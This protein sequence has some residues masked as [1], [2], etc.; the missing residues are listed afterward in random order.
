MKLRFAA[1]TLAAAVLSAP[2]GAQC[3]TAA[4]EVR[5]ACY[6]ATDFFTYLTPQFATALAGGSSTLGQ[7][8]SLGGLGRFALSLRGTGIINGVMPEIGDGGFNI[9]GQ[10][11]SYTV[12]DQIIPGAGLDAAVGL[13]KGFN[14]G[15]TRVGGIDLL[16]SA[17]YI[18][19]VDE[20]DVS[21]KAKDGNL[22]LGYGVR[23]GLLDES[24]VVPG[25]YASYLA[26]DLPTFTVT[27]TSDGGGSG[28]G[29]TFSLNDFT[30]KTTA[31]R[32]V[33]AKNFLVLGL[34][35]GVGQDS[36]KGST[37]ISA[38]VQGQQASGSS[39]FSMTRTNVFVGASLNLFLVK[40]V[41]EYGQ[42]SGGKL[43]SVFN[44]FDKA[45]DGSRTY[46]SLGLRIAF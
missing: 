35:A 38:T 16:V 25:V 33:A 9:N 2:A 46:G 42:V 37:G 41:G 13:T 27:G 45:A 14:L 3:S 8:G 18:P 21:V 36:Y 7:S 24:L 19:D 1:A 40:V 10:P 28:V 12:K 30:V 22:K 34:Q 29:G 43:P 39:S 32:L 11:K 6:A 44:S 20:N 15:A 17:L 26:R 4:T 5:Q 23:V 31:V